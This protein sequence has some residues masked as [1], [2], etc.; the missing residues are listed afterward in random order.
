M[1][2]NDEVF[3]FVEILDILAMYKEKKTNKTYLKYNAYFKVQEKY[4]LNLVF[5][6]KKSTFVI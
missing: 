6:Y 2:E 5:V 1:L 4:Y 3:Y